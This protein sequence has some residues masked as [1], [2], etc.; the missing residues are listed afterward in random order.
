MT[1]S[2]QMKQRNAAL[3][4]AMYSIDISGTKFNPKK[5]E[6]KPTMTSFERGSVFKK[7]I[8]SRSGYA[9]DRQM[10]NFEADFM[11]GR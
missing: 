9:S 7:E 1:K 8:T 4:A 5:I 3:K 2:E 6:T 10:R 11:R